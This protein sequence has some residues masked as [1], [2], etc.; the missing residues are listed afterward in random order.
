MESDGGSILIVVIANTTVMAPQTG[1]EWRLRLVTTLSTRESR[2][3][4]DEGH[5]PSPISPENHRS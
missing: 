2:F 4:T 1:G 3:E 5:R